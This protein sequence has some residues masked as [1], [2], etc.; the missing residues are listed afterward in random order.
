MTKKELREY[1]KRDDIHIE[2]NT[3]RWNI[4]CEGPILGSYRGTFHFAA[5]LSPSQILAVG[6]LYREL[7]G[8]NSATSLAREDNL[9]QILSQ[10]KYRVLAPYPPFWST[11]V[12]E[13]GLM[14][15]IPDTN[16][17]SIIF[18][19]SLDS[20]LKYMAI[21]EDKKDKALKKAKQAGES[22]IEEKDEDLEIEK[23][24][25]K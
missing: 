13:E 15:D 21:L 6:R 3:A 11:Y 7:L 5:F 24:L 23:E 8:P 4:N 10:L 25:D 17:L 22:I 2:G 14:G 19:A 12:S 1:L 16:V 18:D 9:S 20:Q